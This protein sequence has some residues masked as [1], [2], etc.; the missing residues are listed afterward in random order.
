MNSRNRMTSTALAA[1][2]RGLGCRKKGSVRADYPH[3]LERMLVED[4]EEE[5]IGPRR[6]LLIRSASSQDPWMN[7]RR[8][9]YLMVAGGVFTFITTLGWRYGTRSQARPSKR[10]RFLTIALPLAAYLIF[11]FSEEIDAAGYP[12]FTFPQRVDLGFS[13]RSTASADLNLD[14]YPEIAIGAVSGGVIKVFSS[15]QSAMLTQLAELQSGNEIRNVQFSLLDGDSYPDLFASIDSHFIV[16]L[17][18][19]SG[20]LGPIT[21]FPFAVSHLP[22]LADLSGDGRSDIL[23]FRTVAT[24]TTTG[25]V[26]ILINDGSGGFL[27]M[28]QTFSIGNRVEAAL[29]IDLDG[30]ED[31]DAAVIGRSIGPSQKYLLI[32]V[33]NGSGVF[34]PPQNYDIDISPLSANAELKSG[35]FNN[36]DAPD[37]VVYGGDGLSAIIFINDGDGGFDST[38]ILPG[39]HRLVVAED[40]NGDNLTDLAY[41]REDELDVTELVVRLNQ[42]NASFGT[43]TTNLCVNGFALRAYDFGIDGNMDLF[44]N[45]ESGFSIFFNDGTGGFSEAT[46]RGS[47]AFLNPLDLDADGDL[48]LFGTLS[49]D[50]TLDT[51]L[52]LGNDLFEDVAP[53]LVQTPGERIQDLADLNGDNSLDLVTLLNRDMGRSRVCVNLNDGSAQFGTAS[54]YPIGDGPMR[55]VIHEFDGLDGLDIAVVNSISNS[56]SVL[57]NC[58]DGSFSGTSSYVVGDAP[59]G[60][61]AGDL[62]AENEIDLIVPNLG[63]DTVSLL[64]NNGSGGFD[65]TITIGVGGQPWGAAVGDFDKSGGLDVAI[66][67]RADDSVVF[68]INDSSGTFSVSEPLLVGDAPDAIVSGDWDGNGSVDLAVSHGF[69]DNVFVLLNDNGTFYTGAIITSEVSGFLNTGDLDTDGDL[70]IFTS[71]ALIY[72]NVDGVTF[73]TVQLPI[74]TVFSGLSIGDLDGDQDLDFAASSGGTSGVAIL[75]NVRNNSV[76]RIWKLFESAP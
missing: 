28:N 59:N 35:D 42:G 76:D 60:I 1:V 43:F 65:R 6:A 48:D 53:L 51:Y 64:F 54:C 9:W 26:D 20:S 10:L 55:A 68:L 17:N 12:V 37:I 56:V 32:F 39:Q 69:S 72:R 23:A 67:N 58:G 52:N 66:T 29:V 38:V 34:A 75:I 45:G 46:H 19:G 3:N 4:L 36:D 49:I 25:D 18:D 21:I 33:N 71:G 50:M 5:W 15:N 62:D 13:G 57:L 74:P 70:D 7:A 40:L 61:A 63:S 30:D 24:G 44:A 41:L 11:Q 2:L 16:A 47:R 14:S 73:T 22:I 31:L 8:K 27:Q